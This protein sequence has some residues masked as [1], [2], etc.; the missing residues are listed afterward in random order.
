MNAGRCYDYAP[1][2]DERSSGVLS[3][4]DRIPQLG[5]IELHDIPGDFDLA[6]P[7]AFGCLPTR[8]FHRLEHGD[9]VAA[10]CNYNC[11]TPIFN[12]VK[13]R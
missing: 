11:M 8:F 13:Q 7:G 3:L 1:T 9:G 4:P 2:K 10:L 12:F 6:Y 5:C